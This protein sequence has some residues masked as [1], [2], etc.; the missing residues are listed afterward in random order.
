MMELEAD[1]EQTKNYI[2]MR[3]SSWPLFTHVTYIYVLC[4]EHKL[5]VKYKGVPKQLPEVEAFANSLVAP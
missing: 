2:Y 3:T 4:L 5:H 1:E